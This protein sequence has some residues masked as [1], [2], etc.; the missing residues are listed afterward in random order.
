MFSGIIFG[1]C[2]YNLYYY[3]GMVVMFECLCDNLCIDINLG[4]R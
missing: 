2:C 4:L 3:C 1:N